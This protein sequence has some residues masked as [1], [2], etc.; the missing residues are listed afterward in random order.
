MIKKILSLNIN[1]VNRLFGLDLLR[2]IAIL[3]VLL[4]HGDLI[5]RQNF[6]NFP[7][8]WIIDGV[9]IF[10]V[11]SGY[12]IGNILIK[13]FIKYDDTSIPVSAITHFWKRRWFRTLPPYF[14]VLIISLI[15][16]YIM[17]GNF[18]GFSYK[19]IFFIQNLKNPHPDFFAVAWSLAV[20][21]WFYLL[22]PSLVFILKLVFPKLKLKKI[23]L[24]AILIFIILPIFY[25]IK[26]ASFFAFGEHPDYV[27][28]S[29][30]RKI[31]LTRLDTIVFGV[32]GAYINYF[33][34]SFWR[35]YNT[36]SL[37]SVRP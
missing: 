17:Y 16:C 20:E 29:F 22:F 31:V 24:I 35:K 12:L 4:G 14:L 3:I 19:Y 34:S 30:F 37:I 27:W 26:K 13:S 28:D 32:L 2:A 8:F 25:K 10:F 11:L 9:D 33:Y 23:L 21:E 18:H 5:L 36:F 1:Y 15:I 6:P 7:V